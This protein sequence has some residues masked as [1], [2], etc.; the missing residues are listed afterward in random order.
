MSFMDDQQKLE[1]YTEAVSQLA[2]KGPPEARILKEPVDLAVLASKRCLVLDAA[3]NPPTTAHWALA[4]ES[5]RVANAE[6]ILLQLAVTNVDKGIE[7]ADLGQR[8]LMLEAISN[9]DGRTGVSICS[10]ARFVDKA[11][12]LARISPKTR[13]IFAIGFDTLVR[14]VDPKYYQDM[15]A[16]LEALFGIADFAVANRGDRDMSDLEGYLDN[17]ALRSYENNIHQVILAQ[18]LA[19]ISSSNI[20]NAIRIGRPY[21]PSVSPTTVRVIEALRLYK[22]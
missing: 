2:P 6:T 8:L 3:F 9:S 4:Q 16:D 18:S 17:P 20:R 7:G 10:H 19:N 11:A 14:L 13:F 15:E 21:E 22:E 12:A 5:A 1:S